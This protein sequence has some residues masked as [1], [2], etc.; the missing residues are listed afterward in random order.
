MLNFDS[1]KDDLSPQLSRLSYPMYTLGLTAARTLGPVTPTAYFDDSQNPT[2]GIE[3]EA[4]GI[5]EGKE[6]E[7]IK[8]IWSQKE[9]GSLRNHGR[10]FV[11]MPLQ[12][13]HL[14]LAF[15]I[16]RKYAPEAQFSHR[17]STHVHV[18][19]RHLTRSQI[20]TLIVLYA[21]TEPLLFA[22]AGRARQR[23]NFCVGLEYTNDLNAM[24]ST[25]IAGKYAHEDLHKYAALNIIPT[26][27]SSG[28]NPL[29]GTFEFRHMYGTLHH[30]SL[31]DWC[32]IINRLRHAAVEIDLPWVINKTRFLNI[33]SSYL[34]LIEKVFQ[35][36][37]GVFWN[38]VKINNLPRLLERHVSRVKQSILHH[39]F[40]RKMLESAPTP[41][42]QYLKGLKRLY[43][44]VFKRIASSKKGTMEQGEQFFPT[45]GMVTV[46]HEQ[47]FND[48][49]QN[50]A[51][52]VHSQFIL[53]DSTFSEPE[54]F[55]DGE[56]L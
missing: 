41:G 22:F 11:T 18:D 34:H 35:E 53:S 16:L 43:P 42:S 46:A 13:Q 38:Y 33:D 47:I 23:S 50:Q 39:D 45:V 55:A 17:C 37:T 15:D 9:D 44:N 56:D 51:L 6:W 49:L 30:A 25:A 48:M 26:Y 31:M 4:E 12:F 52:Q 29:Y 19:V 40:S 8:G 24:L 1:L 36:Y 2:F 28:E 20:V 10:E 32:G 7:G 54:E 3:I 21:L 14:P 5:D 27:L